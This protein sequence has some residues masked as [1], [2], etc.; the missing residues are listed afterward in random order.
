MFLEHADADAG[1]P[2]T[3]H[4]DVAEVDG[5]TR[6]VT[7]VT[8]DGTTVRGPVTVEGTLITFSDVTAGA[9]AI[10]V[11]ELSDG[12]GTFMTRTVLEVDGGESVVNCDPGTLDCE[13]S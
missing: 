4:V 5:A 7:L 2:G 6:S 3:I 1:A 10:H 12:G 9:Y 8:S 13:V 11:E